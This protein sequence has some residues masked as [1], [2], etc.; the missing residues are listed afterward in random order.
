MNLRSEWYR[1]ELKT[2]KEPIVH[3]SLEEENFFYQAV[4]SGDMDVVKKNCMKN[5][6]INPEGMG[7]LSTNPL[8]NI[9][10]H[11]VVTVAMITRCCV[12]AGMEL[13]QAYQLSDFYILKMD[14]CNSIKDVNQLHKT[15]A[16]D[17]TE[18]MLFLKKSSAISKS[19]TLCIDYIYSH[20]N[21]R[22]T[23][24][25]LA[26][27]VSLSPSYLSR[28]FKKELGTS[29]S[30]YITKR[31]IE[32]AQNLLRYSDSSIIDI[33]NYLSFSSQSHFIQVFKNTVG[34]T[35]KKYRDYF[36]RISW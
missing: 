4:S 23:I 22:I 12:N 6:F 30:E 13:E 11:F 8:T 33:A 2:G 21:S 17:Y 18:K 1:Q 29:I 26:E 9:K 24:E 27:Y 34:L 32:K 5:T 35:P 7:I 16:I 10:Y 31:K 15:M 20:I 3:R 28:L 14:N 25:E 19:I 36:Y